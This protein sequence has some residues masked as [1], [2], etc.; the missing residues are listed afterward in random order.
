MSP[1]RLAR[2]ALVLAAVFA[3]AYAFALL[4]HGFGL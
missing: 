1:A 4:G 2:E 3:C